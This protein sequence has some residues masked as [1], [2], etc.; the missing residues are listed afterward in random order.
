MVK[1]RRAYLILVSNGL[2]HPDLQVGALVW[3]ITSSKDCN[4]H[5]YRDNIILGSIEI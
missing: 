1:H 3:V 2:F 4:I 5:L